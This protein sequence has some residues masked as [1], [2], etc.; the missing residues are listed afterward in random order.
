MKLYKRVLIRYTSSV[1]KSVW[2][3]ILRKLKLYILHVK[4]TVSI[5]ITVKDILN[6]CSGS[7]RDLGVMLGRHCIF[8]V[9]LG[10][11][12]IGY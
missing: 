1:V 10:F 7:V 2:K 6:L 8:V 12:I 3:S 4:V 11:H 5:S 9:V